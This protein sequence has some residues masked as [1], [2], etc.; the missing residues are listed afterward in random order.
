LLL[1]QQK[2]AKIQG[3]IIFQAEDLLRK[4]ESQIREMRGRQMSSV[5]QSPR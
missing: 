3:E 4:K 1:L 2:R 5:L